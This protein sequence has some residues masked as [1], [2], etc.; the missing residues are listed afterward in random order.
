MIALIA[1][2]GALP[3][4]VAAG[5]QGQAYRV[6]ALEDFAP[7][8]L[9]HETF[10]IE[11]LGTFLKRLQEIGTTRVCLIGRIARP[12]LDPARIDAATLPFV[13]RM[14]EAL[15][16]GGDDAALRLVLRLFEEAGFNPVAAHTIVPDLLPPEGV[17]TGELRDQDHHDLIRAQEVHMILSQADVGQGLVVAGGQVLA[18]E[19]LPGTD[20]MLESL[21]QNGFPR[22]AGGL[23]YKAPKAGQDMRIDMPV[24]GPETITR[25]AKAG[26]SGVAI[27]SGGV[28]V[29]DQ[30]A[31]IAAA[32]VNG[33]FLWVVPS[34]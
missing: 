25:A 24:I 9:N 26:L 2:Q 11:Q 34:E 32:Q 27:A 29:V 1:G 17:L 20:W 30:T 22:P 5:L 7:D 8:N 14:M 10:R 18:V 15:K 33:L 31:T 16:V 21:A 28:M 13:P 19:A 6:F 4:R 3:A 12:K 23:F